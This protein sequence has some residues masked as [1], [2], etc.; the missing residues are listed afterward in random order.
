MPNNYKKLMNNKKNNQNLGDF[1][2]QSDHTGKFIPIF[3]KNL[4]DCF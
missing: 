1:N 3:D 2:N 4:C